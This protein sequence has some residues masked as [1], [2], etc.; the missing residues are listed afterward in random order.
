MLD[1]LQRLIKA[2]ESN[3]FWNRLTAAKSIESQKTVQKL[4]EQQQ[5]MDKRQ[6]KLRKCLVTAYEDKVKGVMNDKMFVLLSN[7]FKRERDQLK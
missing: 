3:D 4:M 6:N 2:A 5:K 1:E 7:Q